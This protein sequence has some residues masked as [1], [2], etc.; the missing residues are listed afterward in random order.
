MST[1]ANALDISQAGL[2][3]FDGVSNFT[4]VT[5]TQFNTLVGASSNG[6]TNISPGTSGQVLTSNGAA[7]NPS[8]QTISNSGLPGSG[9]ITLTS[10]TNIN[11]TGSPV[12]LGGA[13]TINV[14]GPIT[15]TSYTS[16]GILFGNGAGA[17]QV[18]AQGAA[19]T[20]LLGN[21]GVPS[22][23]AVPNAALANSSVTLSNGT[24]ITVTGSPL[25]LGGTATIAVSGPP[26]AT[27]LT[28]NGVVF[29]NG[30]SAVGA[31]SAGTTNTV[32]LGNTGS[33]PTFG[34]V[35]NAALSNSSI[36]LANGANITVTGSPVSLGGTAT[37]A[38]SGT[39]NHAIQ[40]GNASG[41]LTSASLLTNGQLLI[42]STGNNP[43]AALLTAGAGITITTG[44][45]S[46]T[47][48]ASGGSVVPTLTFV[49]TGTVSTGTIDF[50]N[51]SSSF[52]GYR[53][54]LVKVT[55]TNSPASDIIFRVSSDG[56]SSYDSAS[57]YNNFGNISTSTAFFVDDTSPLSQNITEYFDI[58]FNNT[59]QANLTCF[60]SRDNSYG[61]YTQQV[62]IN[63]IRFM[64]TNSDTLSGGTILQYGIS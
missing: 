64:C 51:L 54:Y 11:V 10:G 62:A 25:S 24:N 17:L 63:A 32:L 36:T 44:A 53:F 59:A 46:I 7:S 20:V 23:G 22:F 47:I 49:S 31:T 9:Q 43:V 33:A 2:V 18:T 6:I 16:N 50:T 42:G 8:Y 21:G 39:T 30:A 57:N 4:G 3:K 5:V 60:R 28:Q 13:A 27:T 29:G 1:P 52:K 14:A 38:V 56:G 45:G 41:S 58:Y 35:P 40:L 34:A 37:V 48:S 61:Y 26:S 15:P 19:N 12:A 55:N